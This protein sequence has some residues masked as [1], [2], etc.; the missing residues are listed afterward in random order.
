[1]PIE[2]RFADNRLGVV[3]RTVGSVSSREFI[4]THVAFFHENKRALATI[5]YWYSDFS[6][7]DAFDVT[8][9][10]FRRLADACM[11][12]A[13][14]NTTVIVAICAPQMLEFGLSRMWQVFTDQTG[15]ITQVFSEEDGAKAWLCKTLHEDLTFE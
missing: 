5:R 6:D 10:D 8:S 14:V 9:N 11:D 4:D 3:L 12:L 13:R 1:M 7:A 15:W 2:I